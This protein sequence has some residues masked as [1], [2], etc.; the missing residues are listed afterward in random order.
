MGKWLCSVCGYGHEGEM[1]EG[2]NCPVCKQPASAFEK[3]E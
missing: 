3:I 2:F 1:K